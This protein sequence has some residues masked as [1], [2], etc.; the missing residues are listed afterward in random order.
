MVCEVCSN[1]LAEGALFCG[2][3]G[4][5]VY[6][7]A[8]A[9]RRES[10]DTRVL[11]SFLTEGQQVPPDKLTARRGMPMGD[12][13]QYVSVFATPLVDPAPDA[14]P[15][16]APE[17]TPEPELPLVAELPLAPEPQLV[18][19]SEPVRVS[20]PVPSFPPSPSVSFTIT[21]STGETLEV[22]A[23]GLLG[24]MP[25][26]TAGEEFA[27]L[28]IVTDPSRS[29]SKTH[30]EFGFDDE[31]LWILDRNSGNGSIIREFGKIPRR[32][33]PGR[34]YLV[35]RGTR[36]DLGETHLLID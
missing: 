21:L 31:Q 18:P 2:E 1:P 26:P 28:V 33:E 23:N 22:S 19:V 12:D 24:R 30:L 13:A 11:P 25:Q 36:I 4:S 10:S 16:A 27:H 3:C 9:E 20:E 6:K 14:A 15:D 34:K 32:A 29:V 35:P 8:V 17:P 7:Q 5:S